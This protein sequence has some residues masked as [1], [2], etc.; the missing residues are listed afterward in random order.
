MIGAKLAAQVLVAVSG[1]LPGGPNGASQV[2]PG[3]QQRQ[4]DDHQRRFE[5]IARKLEA[6]QRKNQE[7]ARQFH[8]DMLKYSQAA[9]AET[10]RLLKGLE[11]VGPPTKIDAVFIKSYKSQQAG[12]EQQIKLHEAELLKLRPKPKP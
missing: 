11:I 6:L 7:L 2:V 10:Q 8:E 4:F 12:L 3:V 1:L 9:F 5:E